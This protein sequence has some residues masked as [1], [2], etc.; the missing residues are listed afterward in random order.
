MAFQCLQLG[1][2]HSLSCDGKWGSIAPHVPRH[3]WHCHAFLFLVQS[4]N[5]GFH[6]TQ[7]R[8]EQ[9]NTSNKYKASQALVGML[10]L[11]RDCYGEG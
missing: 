8:M 5:T 10:H 2:A 9:G 11:S 7:W 6:A 3:G 1:T 4:F